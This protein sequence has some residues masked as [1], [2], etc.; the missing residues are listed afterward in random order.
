VAAEAAQMLAD[1]ALIGGNTS[2]ASAWLMLARER[3]PTEGPLAGWL[4]GELTLLQERLLRTRGDLSKR[5]EFLEEALERLPEGLHRLRA[6]INL[7]MAWARGGRMDEGAWLLGEIEK[8]L[9]EDVPE[10]LRVELVLDRAIIA[11]IQ[12]DTEE[13]SR[14]YA[15]V[16]A[17]AREAG[18]PQRISQALVGLA[19]IAR[20]RGELDDA[21]EQYR[22]A[23]EIQR[24]MGHQRFTAITLVNLCMVAL[25]RGEL[26][27]ADRWLDEVLDL[28]ADTA[29][30]EV[31][32]VYA[33][34]RALV[35]GRR[36]DLEQARS[37]LYRYQAVNARV[38]LHEP[39]IAEAL[40]EL[41]GRFIE[42][43]DE[44][45]GAE[46]IEAAAKQWEDLGLEEKAAATRAKIDDPR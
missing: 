6:E 35:A 25:A 21:E 23:L 3:K 41:G 43:G 45:Y 2:E 26:D 44:D 28:G 18:D 4:D 19:E 8:N 17:R 10:L 12:E 20:F 40:E 11:D 14:R 34:S 13:A 32:V 16:L 38:G 29:H 27:E 7:A 5:I 24:R 42:S 46:L 15:E 1:L 31:A 37:E 33:F 39:D 30:P 36:G 22:G 9:P